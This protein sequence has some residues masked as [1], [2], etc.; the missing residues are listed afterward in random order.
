VDREERVDLVVAALHEAE[1][2][3]H[4]MVQFVDVARPEHWVR[5]WEIGRGE[6]IRLEVSNGAVPGSP[7]PAL[8]AREIDR[9]VELGVGPEARPNFTGLMPAGDPRAIGE[10]VEAIFEVL[11]SQPDF[12]VSVGLAHAE[13]HE[14]PASVI[15]IYAGVGHAPEP[16]AGGDGVLLGRIMAA[17]TRYRPG[18]GEVLEVQPPY[19]VICMQFD[20]P[21]MYFAD[22]SAIMLRL[23][24]L[25]MQAGELTGEEAREAYRPYR[26]WF[27]E[28]Y[29]PEYTEWNDGGFYI[30]ND[31]MDEMMDSAITEE[32]DKA[33]IPGVRIPWGDLSPMSGLPLLV[34]DDEAL[35][36][37]QQHFAGRYVIVPT[38]TE[39]WWGLTPDGAQALFEAARAND[40]HTGGTT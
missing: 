13:W 17:Q 4:A 34:Q 3:C 29:E 24:S 31:D 35:K 10:R 9:L 15:D 5:V 25:A 8:N 19:V 23:I 20:G 27:P 14:P 36:R 11:G 6:T 28:I 18:N 39:G 30:A 7:L 16:G 37:L 2:T 22:E 26:A 1:A 33:G 38:G 32:A 12:V 40:E 21:Y